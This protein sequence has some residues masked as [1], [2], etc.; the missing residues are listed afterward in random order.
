ML[1]RV[2]EQVKAKNLRRPSLACVIAV[3]QDIHFEDIGAAFFHGETCRRILQQ[4]ILRHGAF[5]FRIRIRQRDLLDGFDRHAVFAGVARENAGN[6]AVLVEEGHVRVKHRAVAGLHRAQSV[7]LA[8]FNRCIVSCCAVLIVVIGIGS[9]NFN[10]NAFIRLH[11]EAVMI[12]ASAP[13][14]DRL[15][16]IN[17]ALP[18]AVGNPIEDI[19][20]GKLNARQLY[21][22]ALLCRVAE[23]VKA[24]GSRRSALARIIAVCQDI[25][26]EDIGFA[27]FHDKTLFGIRKQ[28]ILCHGAFVSLIFILQRDLLDGFDRYSV[29]AGVMHGNIGNLTVLVEEGHI[30][31]EPRAVAGLHRAQTVDVAPSHRHIHSGCFILISAGGVLVPELDADAFIRSHRKT[32]MIVA[33]APDSNLV[34]RYIIT[35]RA[36]RNPP[37]YTLITELNARQLYLQSVVRLCRIAEK[38]KAKGSRRSAIV[39]AVCQDIHVKNI[40]IALFQRESLARIRKQII[41]RQGTFVARIRIRQRDL[42]LDGRKLVRCTDMKCTR[43]DR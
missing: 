18:C 28:I 16:L 29:R 9:P 17:M 26:F 8:P 34:V 12:G 23:Q 7:D 38:I 22:F 21:P 4:I 25:H 32:V 19:L 5:V 10:P 14:G 31:I 2:A 43:Q 41:L 39:M 13:Q 42:R 15:R 24:E 1:C 40:G 30:R 36:R 33:A 3:R 35:P 20:V 6:F 11:G 37:Q 27:V